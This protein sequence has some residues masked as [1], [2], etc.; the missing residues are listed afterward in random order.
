MRQGVGILARLSVGELD[1]AQ[2]RVGKL[3]AFRE[4]YNMPAAVDVVILG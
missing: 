1:L 2:L 3:E 4:F